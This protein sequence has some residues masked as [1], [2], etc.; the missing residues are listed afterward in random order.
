MIVLILLLPV[1][2]QRHLIP[3]YVLGRK[4]ID[5]LGTVPVSHLSTLHRGEERKACMSEAVW[6]SNS[7]GWVYY[8]A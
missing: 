3:V 2:L 4:L 7:G 6:L 5:G 1:F 8:R